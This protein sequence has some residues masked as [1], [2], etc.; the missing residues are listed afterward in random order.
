MRDTFFRFGQPPKYQVRSK[1][2]SEVSGMFFWYAPGV[3]ITH[4]DSSDIPF[5][6]TFGGK[7]IYHGSGYLSPLLPIWGYFYDG[8]LTDKYN[9]TYVFYL[10]F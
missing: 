3:N 5:F 10:K 6:H 2:F 9:N 8:L 1:V 4:I 7:D